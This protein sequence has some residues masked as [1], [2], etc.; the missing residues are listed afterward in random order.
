MIPRKR[1]KIF[2]FETQQN[3]YKIINSNASWKCVPLRIKCL[4]SLRWNNVTYKSLKSS[5]LHI[6]SIL[7]L[8]SN[9]V[10][11]ICTSIRSRRVAVQFSGGKNAS[12][13]TSKH[14]LN[15]YVIPFDYWY[16]CVHPHCLPMESNWYLKRT[17]SEV[18]S[19]H[20]MYVDQELNLN[21]HIWGLLFLQWC[22]FPTKIPEDLKKW[23]WVL[24]PEVCISCVRCMY[25]WLYVHFIP[26]LRQGHVA[27]YSSIEKPVLS[28]AF[29]NCF[30]HI[31]N[32]A[33]E[34]TVPPSPQ[35][36]RN[37]VT[38]VNLWS[39]M[40]I[41]Y[42][43]ND[44]QI[45]DLSY[46]AQCQWHLWMGRH[47]WGVALQHMCVFL[48]SMTWVCLIGSA[49]ERV[50]ARLCWGCWNSIRQMGLFRELSLLPKKGPICSS[51]LPT[52]NM[53]STYPFCLHSSI[54]MFFSAFCF[55]RLQPLIKTWMHLSPFHSHKINSGNTTRVYCRFQERGK[56]V[57][58]YCKA[59]TAGI[60][61]F[62][63]TAKSESW[64]RQPGPRWRKERTEMIH[65]YRGPLRAG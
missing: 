18:Q 14:I 5:L 31:V 10:S 26:V 35:R 45:W 65:L 46:W 20:F 27:D 34:L 23:L 17:E 36:W 38:F 6:D 25:F 49:G 15:Y 9:S 12:F 60:T 64:S 42:Y 32:F 56:S 1:E 62:G 4:V 21:G 3:S 30:L 48:L 53:Y 57:N 59:F 37:Q 7:S 50:C 2:L 28:R 63:L 22:L 54:R 58:L 51:L 11:N 19:K 55:H 52:I 29:P 16:T 8:L 40:L 61:M 39:C 47:S 24:W 44:G 13:D 41:I 43:A 33:S